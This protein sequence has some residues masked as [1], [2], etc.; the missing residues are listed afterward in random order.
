MPVHL[1]VPHK[2]RYPEVSQFSKFSVSHMS[3]TFS[4]VQI[5][6]NG[7]AY[8]SNGSVYFDSAAW[9]RDRGYLAKLKP[10]SVGDLD[11]LAEGE[12]L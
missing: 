3:T 6:D 5:I 11:A 2:A 10:E 1:A 7:Y 8:S 12:G 4:C 9:R